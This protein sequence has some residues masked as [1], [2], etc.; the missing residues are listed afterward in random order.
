MTEL[1]SYPVWD[2]P[3]R[4]FHWINALC[5]VVLTA[6]GLAILYSKACC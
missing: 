3:T 4:W 5:I 1:R 2:A 6:L